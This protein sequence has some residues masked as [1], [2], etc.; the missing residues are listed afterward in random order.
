MAEQTTWRTRKK[1]EGGEGGQGRRAASPRSPRSSRPR[2]RPSAPRR[3]PGQ[4]Q[5]QR[6]R[7]GGRS[8]DWPPRSCAVRRR[9]ACARSTTRSCGPTLMQELGLKN[10]MQAPKLTSITVNMGLGEAVS[11]PKILDTRGRGAGADHRAAAG[12][13]QG[14][15]VHRRVQAARRPE[16]RGHGDPAPGH[17]VRVLRS[18]GQL[19]P[20]ARARLQG[21]VA[22][23]RSTA[24][25]TTPS[26]SGKG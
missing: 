24:G 26:A 6:W 25:A 13:D 8:R 18:P 10:I 3:G 22:P 14:Q 12:G 4:G 23:G 7:S 20:A 17:H 15:E 19:R 5:G 16:D 2:R 9:R 11:N 21:R 1:P